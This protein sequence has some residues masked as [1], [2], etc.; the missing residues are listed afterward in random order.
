MIRRTI[1]CAALLAALVAPA[2][3]NT[4]SYFGFQIGISNAPP[5][6]FV[7]SAPPP[8]VLVPDTR[9]YV[10]DSDECDYDVFRYGGYWYMDYDGY[11]YR[12]PRYGGPFR[13]ID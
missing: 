12:A 8:V 13:V 2:S 1:A 10:V 3:A 11:W 6:P 9:V 7:F 4:R 5:P